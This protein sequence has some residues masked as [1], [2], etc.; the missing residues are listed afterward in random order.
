MAKEQVLMDKWFWWTAQD[1]LYTKEWEFSY[2]ENLNVK[3]NSE[4]VKLNRDVEHLFTT[5]W[6]DMFSS[7][8]IKEWWSVKTFFFWESWEVYHNW[9]T[10]DT[11]LYT[12]WTRD[13]YDSVL[14]NWKLYFVQ[15]V[16]WNAFTLYNIT[17]AN[18]FALTWAGNVTSFLQTWT[19]PDSFFMLNYQDVDLHIWAGKRL[20][21]YS[22]TDIT[23]WILTNFIDFKSEI[24]WLTYT[25]WNIKVYTE[26]GNVTFIDALDYS[27]K[28][29]IN[30]KVSPKIVKTIKS[31][32]YIVAGFSAYDSQ[33]LIMSWYDV[34]VL[35]KTNKWI[36]DKFNFSVRSNNV[37]EFDGKQIYFA[38]LSMNPD[39]NEWIVSYW[40]ERVWFPE[41]FNN[42]VT[43]VDLSS[44]IQEDINVLSLITANEWTIYFWYVW[45]TN[46][47][48]IWRVS[49]S[50]TNHTQTWTLITKK[51]NA[52][53]SLY[54]K[55]LVEIEIY[56]KFNWWVKVAT[57][58]DDNEKA[59]V[60]T[61]WVELN[62]SNTPT[63]PIRISTLSTSF[64]NI[65]LK[66]QFDWGFQSQT[67]NKLYW[68]KISYNITRV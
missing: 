38:W 16:S 36:R 60:F 6:N 33:L 57:I 4:Y 8:S 65:A 31:I 49:L 37:L 43:K 11:A 64:N 63:E 9:S 7:T 35:A 20:Y 12:A 53:S 25:W 10:S 2:S 23:T 46:W 59:E 28:V 48:W 18:A 5:N 58:V 32:D 24:K 68:A 29:V 52:G 19:Q 67:P 17:E 15:D 27:T 40:T 47:Q 55:D 26:D 44:W 34:K 41:W 13:I 66:F 22:K 3:G 62:N 14:F 21:T 45:S 51:F 56:W 54:S 50:T 61:T 30:I 39:G 42:E 1:D